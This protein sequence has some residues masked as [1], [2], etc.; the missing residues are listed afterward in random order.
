MPENHYGIIDYN[1]YFALHI[2][3]NFKTPS[4]TKKFE[5]LIMKTIMTM[6]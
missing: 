6:T 4:T 5:Y 3:Y 1:L 2:T